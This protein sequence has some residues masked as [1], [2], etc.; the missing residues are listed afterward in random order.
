MQIHDKNKRRKRKKRLT[1]YPT[2]FKQLAVMC[3][4]VWEPSGVMHAGN[5]PI[6]GSGL[7][8]CLRHLEM[9]P[10]MV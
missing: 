4:V 3:M 1:V 6:F 9:T 7:E 2:S 5:L 10:K 8:T